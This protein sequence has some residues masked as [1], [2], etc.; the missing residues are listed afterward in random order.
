MTGVPPLRIF[1]A[2]LPF[3]LASLAT[4]VLLAWQP[5]LTLALL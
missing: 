1:R 5:W 3:L 2:L 4:L